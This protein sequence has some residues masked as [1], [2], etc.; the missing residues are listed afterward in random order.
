M[1]NRAA[2][3]GFRCPFVR[4]C[5]HSAEATCGERQRRN[6]IGERVGCE[7]VN[8]GLDRGDDAV[9]DVQDR[10]GNRPAVP[11]QL[12]HLGGIAEA[13][14][15]MQRA[16][17]PVGAVLGPW[18][19]G[20]SGGSSP[21]WSLRYCFTQLPSVISFTPSSRATWA[22]GR[23][24]SITNCTASSRNSGLNL[25]YFLA[26]PCITFRARSY[27]IVVREQRGTSPATLEWHGRSPW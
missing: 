14:D 18:G 24:P 12:A 25:R 26:I 6:D 17:E 13:A 5:N 7:V 21:A 15:L 1:V 20:L 22:I 3:L 19:T 16:V 27:W 8:R 23:D 2:R 11:V 4:R 9:I 10:D